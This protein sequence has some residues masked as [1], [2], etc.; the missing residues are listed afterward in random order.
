MRIVVWRTS[1][2]VAAWTIQYWVIVSTGTLWSNWRIRKQPRRMGESHIN[3][4]Q[5]LWKFIHHLADDRERGSC[6]QIDWRWRSSSRYDAASGGIT[7]HPFGQS[8]GT[9]DVK[10][11]LTEEDWKTSLAHCGLEVGP[12]KHKSSHT[13]SSQCMCWSH[14]YHTREIICLQIQPLPDASLF[15]MLW[16]EWVPSHL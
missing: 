16:W 3:L 6:M 10:G 9:S 7:S 15:P 12:S 2:S 1:S 13:T 8:Q 14:R 5:D 11:C 4:W